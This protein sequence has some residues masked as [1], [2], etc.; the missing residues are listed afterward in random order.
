[1]RGTLHL[2]LTLHCQAL[3][4]LW[5]YIDGSYATHDDM[6]GQSGAVL[7]TGG[8]VVLSKSN[9]QKV[10]TRSS[11]ESE[12]IAVDDALPSVQWTMKF[13][14]EQGYPMETIIKED[15]KSTMLLMKNG[16]LSSGK[17]TKHLD[18]RYFYVKDLIDRGIL[19]V[20]HCVSDQMLADYF[21]KPIQGAKFQQFRDLILNLPTASA[22]QYRS[23]L[24]NSAKENIVTADGCVTNAQVG[25]TEGLMRD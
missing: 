9:K 14:E 7:M 6:K 2:C 22:S 3:D 25:F 20:E 23:V 13:M 11:T 24:E 18:I 5:W 8:C 16:R 17:R 19:K 1:L 21:T 12:L 15:N 10:N 4:K